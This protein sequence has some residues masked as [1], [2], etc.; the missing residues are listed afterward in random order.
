[1]P[2][3]EKHVTFAMLELVPELL[4]LVLVELELAQELLGQELVVLGQEQE[5]VA[6]EQGLGL[7]PA[8]RELVEQVLALMFSPTVP[9]MDRHHVNNLTLTG[10]E[11]TVQPTVD[12]VVQ[13]DQP[14]GLAVEG[15]LV[16]KLWPLVEVVSLD[17]AADVSTKADII[18]WETSGKM[19]VTSTAHVR[20]VNQASS[21][22]SQGVQ[23][24]N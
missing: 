18:Q 5:L 15:S 10:P 11:R 1:L 17:L 12:I 7:E 24:T 23:I 3:A 19:A 21:D 9:S 22:V 16:S 4:A 6:L 14:P 20:M 8:D 2:T 13:S